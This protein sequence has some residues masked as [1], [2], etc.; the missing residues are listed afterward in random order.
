MTKQ[1]ANNADLTYQ[2]SVRMLEEARVLW[3]REMELLCRV[4]GECVCGEGGVYVGNRERCV[5]VE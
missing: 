4:G 3:E 1:A 5:C 2:E